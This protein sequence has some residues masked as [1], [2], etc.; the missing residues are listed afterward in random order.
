[1]TGTGLIK[2]RTMTLNQDGDAAQVLIANL[3]MP[4]RPK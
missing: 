3:V 4:R 1:V 2:V